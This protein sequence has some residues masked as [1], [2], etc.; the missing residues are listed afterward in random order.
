MIYLD[1]PLTKIQQIRALHAISE[2]GWPIY[3]PTDE[4][5]KLKPLQKFFNLHF[6][7]GSCNG[8]KFSDLVKI[9]HSKPTTRIARINRILI[10]PH[11]ITESLKQKWPYSRKHKFSFAGLVTPTRKKAIENWLKVIIGEEKYRIP[12]QSR[13]TNSFLAKVLPFIKSQNNHTNK[14]GDFWLWSSRRGRNFPIKSWDEDY[15]NFLSNSEFVLCP[16]G[17]YIWSYR[18]FESVLCGAIPIIEEY[19]EAYEGFR[20]KF[21]SD[22]LG[23]L[24]YNR[25]DAEHNFNL[26]LQKITIPTEAISNELNYFV[27]E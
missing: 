14:Y 23:S 6:E 16:S 27:A 20:F 10:F 2:T 1:K 26:C 13:L 22:E 15:F 24:T 7:T 18:F 9:D 19:C 21:F 4:V 5:Y 3:I 8:V 25:E 17:D 12:N 11:A